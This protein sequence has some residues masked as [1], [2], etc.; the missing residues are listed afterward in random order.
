[1]T[2]PATVADEAGALEP[3]QQAPTEISDMEGV[4]AY[5]LGMLAQGRGAEAIE[6]LVDL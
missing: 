4:R 1:M 5:V 6:M 2:T 3:E